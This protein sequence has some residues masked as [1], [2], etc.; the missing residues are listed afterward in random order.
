MNYRIETPTGVV[1]AENADKERAIAKAR[2]LCPNGILLGTE[3]RPDG[4]EAGF[5]VGRVKF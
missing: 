5:F 3:I 2:I 4:S 1:L